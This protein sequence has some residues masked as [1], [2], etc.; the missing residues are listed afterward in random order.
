MFE[1]LDDLNRLT[2]L[3]DDNRLQSVAFIGSQSNLFTSQLSPE[4][5]AS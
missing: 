2:F 4:V 5:R 1:G 3:Q